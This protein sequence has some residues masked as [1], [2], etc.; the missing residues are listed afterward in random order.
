MWHNWE[1]T[2]KKEKELKK[3]LGASA[4]LRDQLLVEAKHTLGAFS[5]KEETVRQNGERLIRQTAQ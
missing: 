2:K 1:I 4:T 3:G 5:S